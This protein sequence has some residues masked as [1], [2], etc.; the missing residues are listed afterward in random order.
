MSAPP[1][2]GGIDTYEKL[3]EAVSDWLGRDDLED[4]IPT[5]IHLVEADLTRMT[6]LRAQEKVTTGSF[7][8]EQDFINLPDDLVTPRLLRIDTSP[9]VRLVDIVS[10]DKFVGIAESF[11][12]STFS[13]AA[14]MVGDRLYL[15]PTPGVDDDYTLF[16]MARLMPLS[17]NNSTNRILKDAPDALLYGALMHSAP[18]VGN[19][20]RL[21]LWGTLYG[22]FKED[23]RKLEWKARTGGGPLRVRPDKGIDDRHNVG[24]A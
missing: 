19:D 12:Q 5:F 22:G 14:T 13:M 18:F 23:Y 3:V 9:R 17:S 16:Y 4:R 8:A 2:P 7:T 6:L 1:V 21:P 15:A 11:S 10:L 24:G 20:E